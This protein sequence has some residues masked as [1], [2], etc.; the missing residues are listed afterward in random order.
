MSYGYI[1]AACNQGMSCL[2]ICLTIVQVLPAIE[3]AICRDVLAIPDCRCGGVSHLTSAH[4]YQ[5]RNRCILT[6]AWCY[7]SH[8]IY[9]CPSPGFGKSQRSTNK[10]RTT[11]RTTSCSHG[12]RLPIHQKHSNTRQSVRASESRGNSSVR[13]TR[14]RKVSHQSYK[15]SLWSPIERKP[16][17]R[18]R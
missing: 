1:F 6:F 3:H 16:D 8:G 13:Y 4:S 2:M 10:A 14:G 15:L 18:L 17:S 11:R 12:S 5:R 7:N 9:H